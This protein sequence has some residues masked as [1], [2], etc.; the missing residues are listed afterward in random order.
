MSL[1]K[2]LPFF[3]TTL[4][5]SVLF[6][7]VN[8]KV[9][10]KCQEEIDRVLGSR[11]PAI[12]DMSQLVYVMATIMEIQRLSCTAPGS[13]PHRLS[14]DAQVNGYSFSKGTIFMCNLTKFLR[15]PDVFTNP[16]QFNVDRFLTD[17]GKSIRK[18]DQFAPFGIGKRICMG[19]SLAK[20][21]MFLFFVKILQ[22]V[23]FSVPTSEYPLPD[24]EA[25]NAGITLIPDPFFATLKPRNT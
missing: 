10:E 16:D 23:S 18:Y 14:E 21:E 19:E 22:R 1:I 3:S 2:I 17:D 6:M 12:S 13:L 15:D 5:W 8:P 24:P 9:Q 11:N 4:L 20:N 25:Y 7:A